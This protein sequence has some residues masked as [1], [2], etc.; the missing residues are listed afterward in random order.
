MISLLNGTIRAINS[1]RVIIE[2][3]GVGYSVLVTSATSA[4]LSLGA[5]T[6]MHTSLIVREDSL[7]LFGFINDDCY[8]AF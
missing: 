8:Y 6:I 4:S 5:S 7:T 1:D 3:Q 2:V